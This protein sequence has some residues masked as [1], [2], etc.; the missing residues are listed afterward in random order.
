MPLDPLWWGNTPNVSPFRDNVDGL[1]TAGTL[2]SFAEAVALNVAAVD[3]YEYIPGATN[4]G[5]PYVWDQINQSEVVWFA[6][7][8][9]GQL[10]ASWQYAATPDGEA[11]FE[12][13]SGST[14]VIVEVSVAGTVV[15]SGLT[16]GTTLTPV[17]WSGPSL[18]ALEFSTPIP[19]GSPVTA[20]SGLETLTLRGEG[21]SRLTTSGGVSLTGIL[22]QPPSG[23]KIES[24]A[25]S[26]SLDFGG[27]TT[28]AITRQAAQA[29]SITT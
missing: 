29:S 23:A 21:F 19:I 10:S 2:R 9:T 22:L 27:M 12:H 8:G 1:I 7:E 4:S 6:G 18:A 13:A 11:Y 20:G 5:A 24:S 26:V 14:S 25:E 16:S 17:M 15:V 28:L 3:W